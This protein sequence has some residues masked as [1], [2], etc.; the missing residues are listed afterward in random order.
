MNKQERNDLRRYLIVDHRI[1][2]LVTL[3]DQLTHW[4]E[5]MGTCCLYRVIAMILQI[6]REKQLV[7]IH[8]NQSKQFNFTKHKTYTIIKNK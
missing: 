1:R 6:V 2:V 5:Y 8:N 7:D 3:P 4:K